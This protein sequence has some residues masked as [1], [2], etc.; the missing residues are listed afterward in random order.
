MPTSI[1]K[2]ATNTIYSLHIGK[3]TYTWLNYVLDFV[4]ITVQSPA[5]MKAERAKKFMCIYGLNSSLA[6]QRPFKCIFIIA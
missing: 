6:F 2:K 5:D 4:V 1:D 3:E